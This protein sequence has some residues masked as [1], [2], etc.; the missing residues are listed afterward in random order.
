[1]PRVGGHQPA[2]PM[3]RGSKMLL[4]STAATAKKRLQ[5]AQL[6]KGSPH[7]AA[8]QVQSAE[9]PEGIAVSVPNEEP[10]PPSDDKTV[11]ALTSTPAI[12]N[13]AFGSAPS[14]SKSTKRVS[15]RAPK[16]DTNFYFNSPYH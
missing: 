5:Q 6:S 12:R 4:A 7:N 1:M 16:P 3:S 14:S 9:S 2:R 8:P 13:W 11:V 10:S 15:R